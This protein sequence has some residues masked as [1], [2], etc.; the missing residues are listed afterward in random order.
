MNSKLPSPV[1]VVGLGYVGLPLAVALGEVSATV[2]FDANPRRVAELQRG[3]D[4]NGEVS[5]ERL[6]RTRLLVTSDPTLTA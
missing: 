4:R 6:S 1:G 3:F 5:S 2:G